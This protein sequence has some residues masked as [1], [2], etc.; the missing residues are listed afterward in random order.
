MQCPICENSEAEDVTPTTF[1]GRMI[2]CPDC[3]EF[4]LSGTLV[5]RKTLLT[6]TRQERREALQRARRRT[7][8][9][10]RPILLTYD[11]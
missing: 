3:G 1:D 7:K 10:W 11:L 6:L 5:A 9:G 4:D 2:R 8:E